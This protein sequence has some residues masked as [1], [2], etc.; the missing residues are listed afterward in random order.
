MAKTKNQIDPMWAIALNWIVPGLGH[1]YI[2]EKVR[3]VIFFVTITLTYWTG[4]LIGGALSTVNFKTNTAWFFAEIFAG[5]YTVLAMLL[6]NLPGAV[7]SYSKTL[8]LATIY[9]G[10]AG[11]L[12]LFVI[13]DTTIRTGDQPEA[14]GQ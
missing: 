8:D 3:G 10:V 9:A 2:G 12:N 5:G 6:G 4:I 14:D 13:L 11:L 1:W 7:P